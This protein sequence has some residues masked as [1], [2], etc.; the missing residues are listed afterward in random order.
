MQ[1]YSDFT[2]EK[3]WNNPASHTA[4]MTQSGD[5]YT[6]VTC[7]GT[8]RFTSEDAPHILESLSNAVRLIQNQFADSNADMAA[9]ELLRQGRK[10]SAIKKYREI[11]L[12]GLKEAREYV[13]N[14]ARQ[15]GIVI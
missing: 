2:W 6:L 15:R 9:L 1:Q 8:I 14:L 3:R 4:G 13:E 11:K 12:C 10:I 7:Q 5:N